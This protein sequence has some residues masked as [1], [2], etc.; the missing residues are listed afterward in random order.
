MWGG[1][2]S[3]FPTRRTKKNLSGRAPF[4]GG[5]RPYS[6]KKKKPPGRA[7]CK[8][9]P[10]FPMS[11]REG[12]LQ[13]EAPFPYVLQGGPPARGGPLSLFPT[14]RVSCK[15]RP[16]PYVL[17]GGPPVRGDPLPHSPTGR[18]PSTG[19]PPLSLE[20]ETDTHGPWR[21]GPGRRASFKCGPFPYSKPSGPTI[22]RCLQHRWSPTLPLG[23]AI[24]L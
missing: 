4:G 20:V 15:G 13:G 2:R 18:A 14:G 22:R 21:D 12:P 6:I 5:P 1:P 19:R 23:L 9:R 3:P 11:Y 24:P 17:Q 16:F 8:G 7:H 10:P